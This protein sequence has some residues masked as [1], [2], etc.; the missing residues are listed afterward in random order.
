[1]AKEEDA[2]KENEAVGSGEL[3]S[4]VQE[5]EEKLKDSEQKRIELI[6]ENMALQNKLKTS[7]E[8]EGCIRQKLA[9]LKKRLLKV[10]VS[11]V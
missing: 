6:H 5:L 4:L 8:E 7:Q 3:L 10:Q 11:R 1:M 2:G 9:N